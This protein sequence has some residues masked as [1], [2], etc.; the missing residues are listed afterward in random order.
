MTFT[1]DVDVGAARRRHGC[2]QPGDDH[3]RRR[4]RA[5]A[6]G[7]QVLDAGG[8]DRRR[9]VSRPLRHQG[10]HP[11]DGRRRRNPDVDD[12][13]PQRRTEPRRR[14]RRHGRAP[15]RLGTVTATPSVGTCTVGAARHLPARHPGAGSD[16][17]H[18]GP[19]RRPAGL[20]GGV[21]HRR[22]P[23]HESPT[24]R[25]Q[26]RTTTRP[27]RRATS[28]ATPTCRSPRR[29]PRPTSRQAARS[30]TRSPPPT[31]VRRPRRPWRSTTR[32]TDPRVVLTGGL[33]RPRRNVHLRCQQRPLHDR[34]VGARRVGR[35][36]RGRNRPARARR[37]ATSPTG[38][39]LLGDPGQRPAPTTRPRPR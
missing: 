35:D 34:L 4:H 19:G 14:R 38:R 17:H 18:H 5:R 11:G 2:R 31:T 7:P 22:R 6:A 15:R 39:R 29:R 23:G 16:R 9:A 32:V 12:H 26:P 8:I 1:F 21:A 27:G 10:E 30:R 37:P 28:P 33:V 3:L 20:D 13:R 24:G 25:P 36:D